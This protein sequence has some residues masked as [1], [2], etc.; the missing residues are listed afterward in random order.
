M[1]ILKEAPDTDALTLTSE[2]SGADYSDNIALV[3]L[4][5]S[6][7]KDAASKLCEQNAGLVRKIAARFLGRGVE[8]EDLYQIGS[9]GMLRAIRSFATE[10]GCAF[11]TYAVPLIMGEIKRFLRDDG[12]IKVSREQKRLG[13]IL[14]RT[15]EK[16]ISERGVEPG[17]S[18]LAQIVGI[19][20]ADASD[21]LEA[22]SPVTMLGEPVFDDERISME[23][24][25][26]ESD[27]CEREFDKI[28]L[29]E[30]ISKLPPLW[31]QIVIC[32]YFKDLSQQKTAELLSLSQVKVSREEK[33]I[34]AALRAEME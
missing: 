17:I 7:D 30:A 22:V 18:E 32:R 33:K 5:Q 25:L 10:R 21:A 3:T 8:F 26:C 16:I 11:S 19:S 12:L 20:P 13:A 29:T 9:I 34:L 31:R 15:R 28:A 14:L 1:N 6:G 23:S 24:T 2:N 27:L 4:A